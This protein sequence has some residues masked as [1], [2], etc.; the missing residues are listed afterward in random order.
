MGYKYLLR[1]TLITIS[2]PIFLAFSGSY[3]SLSANHQWRTR[4]APSIHALPLRREVLHPVTPRLL[5]RRHLSLHC[6]QDPR[7]RSLHAALAH[8]CSSSGGG[9][10]EK[11][12]VI[13]LSS[14][15]DEEG[16]IAATSR[17]FEF[18]Q[19]LW[20]AQLHCPRA[21]QRQQDHCPQRL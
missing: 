7:R 6:H 16:L 8:R 13:D 18:T 9:G 15:S 14:S 10:F 17:D 5:R 3:L 19:R 12:P 21:A 11:A 2:H 4:E 20:R 1:L